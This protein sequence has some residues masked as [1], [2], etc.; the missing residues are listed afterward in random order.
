MFQSK[1]NNVL[2]NIMKFGKF[3]IAQSIGEMMVLN[4]FKFY[5]SF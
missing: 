3:Q 2:K 5:K 4:C 1:R